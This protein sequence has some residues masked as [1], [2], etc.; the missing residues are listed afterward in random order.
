MLSVWSH[1]P[2][3]DV[4]IL[5]RSHLSIIT[6]KVL[7]YSYLSVNVISFYLTQR[8][9]ILLLL[10]ITKPS[11]DSNVSW[12]NK[13]AALISLFLSLSLLS[14]FLFVSPISLFLISLSVHLSLFSSLF[15]LSSVFL[16]SILFLS[17]F[18]SL[19]LL[20]F[21]VLFSLS[22]IFLCSLLSLY[23][24][25]LSSLYFLSPLCQI[26][27]FGS[28]SFWTGSS[29]WCL[30]GLFGMENCWTSQVRIR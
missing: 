3:L 12:S 25:S 30:N 6:V 18:S 26:N 10:K 2:A 23:L 9:H 27:Y 16:C 28:K 14:L 13:A 17:L 21:Y 15:S 5:Y 8:N 22:S 11:C 24:F 19:S 20:S 7:S 29:S 4:I 1:A